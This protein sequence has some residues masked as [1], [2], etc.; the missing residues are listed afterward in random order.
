MA[1]IPSFIPF[2][3]SINNK[4]NSF[5]GSDSIDVL[6]NTDWQTQYLWLA[7]FITNGP[8]APFDKFFPASD[9]TFPMAIVEE[10]SLL[11]GQS[12]F[13]FP[14]GTKTKDISVTF[15]DDNKNTM[16]NYFR[17]WMEIDIGN[18][19]Q[20]VSGLKDNHKLAKGL[21]RTC[22]IQGD[23]TRVHPTRVLQITLLDRYKKK[24]QTHTYRVFPVGQLD[25]SG[26]QASEAKTYTMQFKVVHDAS[27]KSAKSAFSIE[28]IGKDLL[29]RFM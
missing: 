26:S 19:K 9:V 24:V 6:R 15:Y 3:D 25:F 21:A 22:V 16:L 28:D 11:T 1:V 2:G 23:N 10:A 20:F 18:G 14:I 7:D 5:F 27:A 4:I 17:D 8:T 29:G 12:D 13:Y